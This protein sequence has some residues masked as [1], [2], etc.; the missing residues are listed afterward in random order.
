[1][2][3]YEVNSAAY[4][5]HRL[6]ASEVSLGDL[7]VLDVGCN[8]GCLKSLVDDS[9]NFSGLDSNEVALEAA[10]SNG[11]IYVE[12]ID[13]DQYASLKLRGSFDVIIFSDILEHLKYPKEC[14]EFFV[15]Q[16]LAE[17]GQVIIS[18]PNVA[19][20]TIRFK[21]LFGDFTYTDVG[22]LDKT[23]LH[24]YTL[25]TA[26]ELISSCG[27]CINKEKFSSNRFGRLISCFPLLGRLLGFNLIFCARP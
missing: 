3:R 11:Y 4:G 16:Y 9:V 15:G 7:D 5:T 14:L 12:K 2:V 23:H 6:I 18:L 27:L 21:L 13:L 17:K 19:H 20:F 25:E 10:R 24:L 22:I 8:T 1:M 26:R